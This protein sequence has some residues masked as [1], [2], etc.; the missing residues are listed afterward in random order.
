MNNRKL[1]FRITLMSLAAAAV[2]LNGCAALKRTDTPVYSTN[3]VGQVTVSTNVAF[4]PSPKV[5]EAINAVRDTSKSLLPAPY[6]T[7]V[8]VLGGLGLAALSIFARAKTRQANEHLSLL[9]TVIA[10]VEVA[11]QNNL[12]VKTAIANIAAATGNGVALADKVDAVTSNMPAKV[13]ASNSGA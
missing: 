11:T 6:S 9:N 5:V 7:V 8:D 10:G 1:T 3:D 2:M 4:V 12:P 13:P